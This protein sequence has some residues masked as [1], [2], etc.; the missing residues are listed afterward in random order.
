MAAA[1]P[2]I[3]RLLWLR[4]HSSQIPPAPFSCPRAEIP[5]E[6]P[7]R[8]QT[9]CHHPVGK[10]W[11]QRWAPAA[12][13]P[14]WD[15]PGSLPFNNKQFPSESPQAFSTLR[16]SPDSA[17]SKMLLDLGKAALAEVGAEQNTPGF[18]THLGNGDLMAP[19][20]GQCAL[21]SPGLWEQSLV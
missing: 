17:Q 14:H 3:H 18:H 6:M 4:F 20:V 13:A 15:L 12:A 2:F 11:R 19:A 10:T 9:R 5:R 1:S 7:K 16:D 8:K 21:P